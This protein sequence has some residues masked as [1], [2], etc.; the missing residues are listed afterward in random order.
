MELEMWMALPLPTPWSDS[1]S[2]SLVTKANETQDK[3]S[4]REARGYRIM[5]VLA[6]LS[7]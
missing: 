4:R 5:T 7:W 2:T 1:R 3:H 6:R